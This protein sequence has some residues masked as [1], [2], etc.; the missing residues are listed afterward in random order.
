M[1]KILVIEDSKDLLDDVIETLQLEEYEAVGAIDGVEGVEAAKEHLP[2]LIVCDIMM[3]GLNGYGVLQ[4][5]RSMP[6]TATIPFIFVTAK[7]EDEDR[8]MGMNLGADDFL[9][10]PFLITELLTSIQTQLERRERLNEL[11]NKRLEE[12]TK[13]I[14]TALPHE[15]RTPLN[16]IIGFSDMLMMESHELKSD[17]IIDWGSHINTA[18]HRLYRM[19]ENYLYYVRLQ[20]DVRTPTSTERESETNAEFVSVAESEAIKLADKYNRGNDLTLD[21][22]DAPE[23]AISYRDSAKVVGELVDNA[24]KFSEAGQGVHVEG[25]LT[26]EGDYCLRISDQGCGMTR[27]QI[28]R[29]GAYMQFD[30]DKQEQQGLGLGLV[31]IKLLMELYNGDFRIESEPGVGTTVSVLL[32]GV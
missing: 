15:L 11:A 14:I 20:T 7:V 18:A 4:E 17:Q 24:F 12:L 16:T 27:D 1:K 13:N 26:D 19:V 29:I 9:T 6:Q 2:D 31:V 3:P 23:V 30:R 10:K 32:K 5:L 22:A 8:R 28:S 25:C 21:V